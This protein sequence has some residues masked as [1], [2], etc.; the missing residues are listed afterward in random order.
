VGPRL[1]MKYGSHRCTK[2]EADWFP[3]KF[4]GNLTLSAVGCQSSLPN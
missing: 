1:G 3:R 2:P 4:V